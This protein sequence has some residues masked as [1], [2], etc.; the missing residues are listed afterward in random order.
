M[1]IGNSKTGDCDGETRMAYGYLLSLY[2]SVLCSPEV[3]GEANFSSYWRRMEGRE[4][5]A[6]LEVPCRLVGSL[7]ARKN[8]LPVD[9]CVEM[10]SR[11]MKTGHT[12]HKTYNLVNPEYINAQDALNSVSHALRIRGFVLSGKVLKNSLE[13]IAS[14]R[15]RNLSSRKSSARC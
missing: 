1:L 9:D 3:R 7:A 2:Y 15:T 10:I 13:N 8:M 4:N 12:L 14:I 11:I 5:S 6:Y